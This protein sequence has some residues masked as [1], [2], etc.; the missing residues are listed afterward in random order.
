MR[1]YL[2][3]ALAL[4][5]VF[6]ACGLDPCAPESQGLNV[7]APGVG[8]V[9]AHQC[10]A[11]GAKGDDLDG[12]GVLDAGDLCPLTPAGKEPDAGRAGCPMP[13]S[14]ALVFDPRAIEDGFANRNG[15]SWQATAAWDARVN[16]PAVATLAFKAHV[17]PD[18]QHVLALQVATAADL[19]S[20]ANIVDCAPPA[21]DFVIGHCVH[22]TLTLQVLSGG[23]VLFDAQIVT[24]AADWQPAL[25]PA[26]VL[27]FGVSEVL[28][29]FSAVGSVLV[30]PRMVAGSDRATAV[31]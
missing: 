11:R 9:L 14:A 19:N 24:S 8:V 15:V 31:R 27:P 22:R 5:L 3:F 13:T 23:L 4:S 20:G 26:M 16:G 18:L 12:D 6:T 7:I 2:P 25:P 29:K 21:Q 1:T 30:T 28:F 17:A 10:A